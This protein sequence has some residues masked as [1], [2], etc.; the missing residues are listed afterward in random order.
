MFEFTHTYPAQERA[1][2][3]EGLV[4]SRNDLEPE[5]EV[6]G[7]KIAVYASASS[8]SG[9]SSSMMALKLSARGC[10]L[11]TE[12]EYVGVTRSKR[13]VRVLSV[14]TAV[15][16]NSGAYGFW[17]SH[18]EVLATCA[19]SKI[20]QLYATTQDG[21]IASGPQEPPRCGKSQLE[22]NDYAGSCIGVAG[23]QSLSATRCI[24]LVKCAKPRWVASYAFVVEPTYY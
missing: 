20:P 2:D 4:R 21:V 24:R 19:P 10:V 6:V 12:Y 23:R 14:N 1:A 16:R 17:S 13:T 15:K 5:I 11:V 22:Q 9:T 7:K 3:L 18:K 8:T